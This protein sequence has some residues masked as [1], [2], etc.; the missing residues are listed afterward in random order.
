MQLKTY[1]AKKAQQRALEVATQSISYDT[2]LENFQAAKNG[3][4]QRTVIVG[5]LQRE[6]IAGAVNRIQNTGNVQ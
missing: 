3:I 4:L 5:P 2:S 1:L 6:N